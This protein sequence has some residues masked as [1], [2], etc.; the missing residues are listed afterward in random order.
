MHLSVVV[1]CFNEAANLERVVASL[2]AELPAVSPRFEVIL[3][4]DGSSDDTLGLMRRLAA[5]DSRISYVALSRNFGKEAAMLAGLR[6]AAGDAVAIM[7]AD[8][9]H[10]PELLARM[11]PLLDHGFDQVIARRTRD[12]ER[13]TRRILSRLYYR[14]MN[15]LVDVRMQDGAGDFRVLSRRAVDALLALPE[16]NRFSKGLF[17]WIGFDT[18]TVD[19]TNVERHAGSSTWTMRKL[20]N[21]GLDGLVSFN[22]RPLRMVMHFGALVA[23]AAFLYVIWELVRTALYGVE[24]PGYVTL[25]GAVIGLGGLQL[26]VLGVIG[27]YLG[28]I[29]NETKRRPH[30]VI[31][32]TSSPNHDDV[33]LAAEALDVG[34]PA[35]HP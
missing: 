35:H 1:P 17:A 11:V 27:E 25:I 29:Y 12:G 23:L 19:F 13:V 5:A 10:P 7:D 30:F 9:Q 22:T 16:S 33:P 6:R 26:L 21:Y 8:G 34:S 32:E 15:R 4:D 31:K 24:T 20:F 28:R 18:A 3:V 14:L 2:T